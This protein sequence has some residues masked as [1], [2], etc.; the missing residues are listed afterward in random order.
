[1]TGVQEYLPSEN[2]L[3]SLLVEWDH[4]RVPDEGES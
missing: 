4:I 1:M 2:V 3:Q